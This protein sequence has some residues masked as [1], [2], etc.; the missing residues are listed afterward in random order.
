MGPHG[1]PL[2]WGDRSFSSLISAVRANYDNDTTIKKNLK[3]AWPNIEGPLFQ[4]G[5]CD[6]STG[7]Y[8][9]VSQIDKMC[10]SEDKNEEL[11][12]AALLQTTSSNDDHDLTSHIS[13]KLSRY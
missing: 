9:A 3:F 1:S 13:A 10:A 6:L 7:I 4:V 12:K 2:E 8:C 11:Q 5:K